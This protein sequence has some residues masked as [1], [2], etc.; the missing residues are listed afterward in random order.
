[1]RLAADV[2]WCTRTWPRSELVGLAGQL[3]RSAVSIPSNIAEGAGRRTTKEFLSFLYIARGSW[4]EL[5]TQMLLAHE[6]GYVN[7]EQMVHMRNSLDE[8]GRL[9]NAVIASLRRRLNGGSS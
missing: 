1:M 3:Q 5:D 2:Y 7:T 9:L 6:L 8:V 4:A